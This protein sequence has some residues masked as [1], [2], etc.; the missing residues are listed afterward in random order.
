M[1]ALAGLLTAVVL[2]AGASS[3]AT[4]ASW[5]GFYVGGFAG[6]GQARGHATTTT[7]FSPT[8]YFAASSVPA[9]ATA[10]SHSTDGTGY[11]AGVLAGYN[12]QF[13]E[14]WVGGLEVD[15]GI[16]DVTALGG[17]G[18]IYPCC[19]S[20]QFDIQTK[21]RTSW[22]FTARP[23][24]GYAWSNWLAYVTGGLALTDEKASFVFNDTFATA[25]ETGIFKKTSTSWTIGGGI[26]RHFD[27]I[28]VRLEDLYADFGSV[29]GT[30]AN[31]TAFSPPIAFPTNVFTHRASL[32]ENMV[33]FVITVDI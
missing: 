18:A 26:E 25:H 28:S 12:W 32:T 5:E 22:L 9:I 13:D 33:R 8:G 24:L 31:L 4:A 29:G 19:T 15:Y 3:A 14:N 11:N 30:S 2:T 20:T 6:P 17:G 27:G 7:V 16:N 10:G 1:K 21:V 23:R